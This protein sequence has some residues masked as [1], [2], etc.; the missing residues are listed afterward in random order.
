MKNT[1][2]ERIVQENCAIS[3]VEKKRRYFYI[4]SWDS[5]C[6]YRIKFSQK[7]LKAFSEADWDFFWKHGQ[8]GWSQPLRY[9]RAGRLVPI[10][11]EKFYAGRC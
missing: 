5:K 8:E 9:S 3:F 2:I 7:S 6:N 4:S 1:T 11:K 10:P